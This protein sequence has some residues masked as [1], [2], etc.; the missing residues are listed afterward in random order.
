MTNIEQK[1]VAF[2]H[3]ID[4]LKDWYKEIFPGKNDDDFFSNSSKLSLLK[5]LFLVSAVKANDGS[6]LLE[7]FTDFSA[8][9]Y[10]P[11]E[12]DIYNAIIADEI[13]K[14]TIG[15]RSIWLNEKP[16]VA[17]EDIE[18]KIR[19]AIESLKEKNPNLIKSN[20]SQLVNITHKWRSW[21][22]TYDFAEFIGQKGMPMNINDIRN[23]NNR[24]F[25]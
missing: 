21:S 3:M 7:I 18:R 16:L 13:P 2:S 6:D 25:G 15:D 19:K 24:F 8:L 10:G 9:P 22:E 4:L 20:A 5:F 1:K 17:N 23:D 14:Y 12:S 11:V